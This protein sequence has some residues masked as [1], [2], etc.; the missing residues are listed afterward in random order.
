M[1]VPPAIS[2]RALI[3]DYD[4]LIVDTESS[5]YEVWRQLYRE[6]GAELTIPDWLQA[7]GHVDHF[8]P[9]S[10]LETLTGRTLDWPQLDEQIAQS[11]RHAVAKLPPLPGVVTLMQAARTTGWRIGVASNSDTTWVLGGLDRLG[12]SSLVEAVR[13]RDDVSRHKPHPDVYLAVLA[14][15]DA[16]PARSIAFEDSAPGA[17]AARAAGLHV[18]AVPNQLTSH[19]PIPHAHE[20]LA[21]LSD[22]QLT[23]IHLKSQSFQ[24]S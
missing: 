2:H 7:V 13:T 22:F 15:L 21:S 3:F 12:L 18:I 17:E 19:L 11:L 1:T 8:D 16:D 9:R 6:H 20:F 23:R 24:H 14:A 4:G 10:H 5:T